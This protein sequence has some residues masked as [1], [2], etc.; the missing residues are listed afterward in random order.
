MKVLMSSISISDSI[1]NVRSWAENWDKNHLL[2]KHV[3]LTSCLM[4]LDSKNTTNGNKHLALKKI[5]TFAQSIINSWIKSFWLVITGNWNALTLLKDM[6]KSI[7]KYLEY[8]PQS[9]I[10]VQDST[11]ALHRFLCESENLSYSSKVDLSEC[12]RN[13]EK[14]DILQTHSKKI[15]NSPEVQSATDKYAVYKKLMS[16]FFGNKK[17]FSRDT[18]SSNTYEAIIPLPHNYLNAF[19]RFLLEFKETNPKAPEMNQLEKNMLLSISNRIWNSKNIQSSSNRY[20][21]YKILMTHF[22]SGSHFLFEE[23]PKTKT[24]L[25]QLKQKN[26]F[27]DDTNDLGRENLA[28][29]VST[30]YVTKVGEQLHVHLAGDHIPETVMSTVKLPLNESG[31]PIFGK[32]HDLFCKDNN[33]NENEVNHKTYT[34]IQTENHPDGP[35]WTSYSL[36]RTIDFIP[37]FMRKKIFKCEN[38]NVGPYGYGRGDNNPIVID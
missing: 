25:A 10:S 1:N 6:D 23:S 29:R 22:Y 19:Y 32:R 26:G 2:P 18:A 28:S 27:V 35:D 17:L 8:N 16:D 11:N 4:T 7:E 12:L 24:L 13:S 14:M 30:H 9:I 37:Y 33:K 31:K 38:P 5:H 21:E 36:H 34:W 15:W 20:A 3:V